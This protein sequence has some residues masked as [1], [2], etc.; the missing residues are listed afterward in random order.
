MCFPS[1]VKD[2]GNWFPEFRI[3]GHAANNTFRT[4][5]LHSHWQ[6]T[7]LAPKGIHIKGFRH[8]FEF[9]DDIG[10][11]KYSNL[12]VSRSYHDFARVARAV[13]HEVRTSVLKHIISTS[14]S[15]E[16]KLKANGYL[17]SSYSLASKLLLSWQA[18][19]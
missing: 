12:R 5:L 4:Q 7:S 6:P 11:T 13:L 15:G 17:K 19:L 3:P 10:S 1:E 18:Y 2:A 16:I 14:S 9:A 8:T